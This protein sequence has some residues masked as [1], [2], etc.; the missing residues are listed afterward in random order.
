[1]EAMFNLAVA[2]SRGDGGPKN[3]SE[4]G[5]L[6][7]CRA[8]WGCRLSLVGHGFGVVRLRSGYVS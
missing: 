8:S 6:K 4:A 1:M 7:L 3:V 2:L 5:S